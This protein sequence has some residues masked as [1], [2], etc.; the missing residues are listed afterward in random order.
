MRR[1]SNIGHLIQ[2]KNNE[3]GMRGFLF[4]YIT[5]DESVASYKQV[6]K[7]IRTLRLPAGIRQITSIQADPVADFSRIEQEH[8]ETSG[9]RI[10]TLP[11]LAFFDD[12]KNAL[13]ERLFLS[14]VRNIVEKND[15]FFPNNRQAAVVT[16]SDFCD[17]EDIIQKMWQ[18]IK[19]G[20]NVLICGP[21]R[22]GKTSIMRE[23]GD[24]AR[25]HE[26][27]PIM[28]DL[29][30][31]FT[32]EGFIAK[33]WVAVERSEATEEEK[34]KK[35]EEM[36]EQLKDQWDEKGTKIFRNISKRKEKLLFLLD[37]CPYMLD[38][39]LG[40]DAPVTPKIDDDSR[41]TTERFI[42]WF[43][44]Q[45]DL[46]EGRCVYV[47][48]GSI[49][50]SPYLKDNGLNKESFSDCTVLRVPFF[51]EETVRTYI[52]GLLLGREIMLPE[53]VIGELV[54][55]TMP[56][57]PYFIQIV[58]NHVIGLY[59]KNPNFTIE[60]L[61]HAYRAH[62]IG[63]EGRRPF[64]TFERHF[65]RYGRRKPGATAL[66]RELS[67]AGDN[68]VEKSDLAKS[69]AASSDLA[70]GKELDIVLKYLEYD[71]YIE[72]I[73]GTQRYRF[74]SPILRDYWQKNQK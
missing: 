60:D 33:I 51:D 19:K 22:F 26:L 12:K 64:D 21:R 30:S 42:Q 67:R 17:R 53:D 23:V 13:K 29:E 55:L 73:K 20:Q 24:Q 71:F 56:G 57:I 49:N 15:D 10:H 37:E 28:I 27:R 31:V 62:I 18:R 66:L 9:C 35:A 69:Y 61:R 38:S 44:K 11:V 34:N 74:A 72:K 5:G 40:K 6:V 58:M 41:K 47:L 46:T 63:P 3:T 1:A 50:L 43:R 16:G 68:G 7:G 39:F 8:P 25:K 45:R 2:I 48:T 70:G 36:E 14:G 32:P 59:R 52:E 65:K 54:K 4:L